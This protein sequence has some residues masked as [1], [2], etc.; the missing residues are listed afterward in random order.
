VERKLLTIVL[1][2]HVRERDV[3]DNGVDAVFREL[4]VAEVLDPNVV[5]GMPEP[6]D[7]P[8]DRVHLD[9]DESCIGIGEAEEVPRTTARFEDRRV[10]GNTE[11]TD[12]FVDRLDDGGR[13]VER[14]ERRSLR[15]VVL[16]RGEKRPE[17]LTKFLPTD[18]FVLAA[19]R[20]GE[21]RERDRSESRESSKEF[22]LLGGRR[23]AFRFQR[24]E[25]SDRRDDVTGFSLFAG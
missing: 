10:L 20:V 7:S 4:G 23:P 3:A 18:V 11:S 17:L 15:A 14:V 24:F 19:Y 21:D 16:A 13:R 1:Q 22:L 25:G 5:F 6:G 2:L 8:G 12:R 9:A